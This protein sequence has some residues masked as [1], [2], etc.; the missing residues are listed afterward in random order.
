SPQRCGSSGHP[1]TSI[2]PRAT[3]RKHVNSTATPCEARPLAKRT[4]AAM[5]PRIGNNSAATIP[6]INQ[7]SAP[8]GAVSEAAISV[9]VLRVEDAVGERELPRP[10]VE[11]LRDHARGLHSLTV[12]RL[13]HDRDDLRLT[14]AKLDLA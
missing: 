4:I 8:L 3:P 7:A 13:A 10:V 14:H 12:A 1:Y 9:P 11:E 2:T 5:N 6:P